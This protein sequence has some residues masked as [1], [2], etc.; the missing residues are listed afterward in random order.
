M[1][2]IL[3][4]VT[5]F[6][7][8]SIEFPFWTLCQIQISLNA[9]RWVRIM[10]VIACAHLIQFNKIRSVMPHSKW[11]IICFVLFVHRMSFLPFSFHS[12]FPSHWHLQFV[13]L[14]LSLYQVYS[15]IFITSTLILVFH[16]FGQ[17]RRK[18]VISFYVK[19]FDL[20]TWN[21]ILNLSNFLIFLTIPKI[22]VEKIVNLTLN[23]ISKLEYLIIIIRFF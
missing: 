19:W 3:F 12:F 9:V 7:N 14:A 1:S 4:N 18:S 5:T 20:V 15:V 23:G 6:N 21:H 11:E 8:I 10:M 16:N 17:G 13:S 2:W 22:T